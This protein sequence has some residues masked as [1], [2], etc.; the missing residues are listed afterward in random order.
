MFGETTN[1]SPQE[2]VQVARQRLR[3]VEAEL[4]LAQE[5]Y[6]RACEVLAAHEARKRQSQYATQER[7]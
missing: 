1:R 7:A 4:Y 2:R 5:A 6:M 3:E